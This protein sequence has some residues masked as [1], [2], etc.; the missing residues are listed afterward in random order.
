MKF[1]TTT[2]F[3]KTPR[4]KLFLRSTP[5]VRKKMSKRYKILKGA[6]SSGVPEK[7]KLSKETTQESWSG[8]LSKI[9]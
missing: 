4:S 5:P 1:Y 9:M 8:L 6:K 7:W 3:Q 2:F